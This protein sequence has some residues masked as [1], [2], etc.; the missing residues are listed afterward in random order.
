MDRESG[1]RDHYLSQVGATDGLNQDSGSGGVRR[2]CRYGRFC[3]DRI[4]LAPGWG[5]QG[6]GGII[7]LSFLSSDR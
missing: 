2:V 7:W 3:E 6:E 4:N 1:F 5:M